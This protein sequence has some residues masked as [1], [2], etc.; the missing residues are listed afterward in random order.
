MRNCQRSLLFVILF[1]LFSFVEAQNW[2]DTLTILNKQIASQ[3][4]S[5]DL[6]LRK[7]AANLELQ[8][9][10]YAIDEYRQVLQKEPHNPAALFYRAYASTHLRRYVEARND[11]E[12]LLLFI[13]RHL[14]ARLSLAYV[15]Q[16]MGHGQQALDQLNQAVELHADSA[17][18]YATRAAL[19]DEL[20]LIDAA[21][22]DWQQASSLDAQN[23]D[24]VASY[25]DLLIRLG[26]RRQAR[27]VLDRGVRSGISRGDLQQWYNQCKP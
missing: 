26:R 14:Q 5:T 12:T 15:L 13:P 2:R 22:Y 17:V 16:K 25:A 9:W 1:F 3:P 27:E 23:A 20:K 19:E 8:Q 11:Y 6:H 10:Q 7:A 18:A 24:Y 4:W 21:V